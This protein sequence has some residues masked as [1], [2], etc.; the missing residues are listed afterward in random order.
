MNIWT[1]IK[2]SSKISSDFR[3]VSTSKYLGSKIYIHYIHY[4]FCS[5]FF[6]LL[7]IN[8]IYI[9]SALMRKIEAESATHWHG[10]RWVD[11]KNRFPQKIWATSVT[12]VLSRV[13][14]V[15]YVCLWNM[16]YLAT[17]FPSRSLWTLHLSAQPPLYNPHGSNRKKKKET[18]TQVM[19][20]VAPPLQLIAVA[21][22]RCN[23]PLLWAVA[24]THTH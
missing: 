15:K 8:L 22:H 5:C 6:F 7:S 2:K 3:V 13:C 4:K 21:I 10:Y 23:A 16:N 14:L 24:M 17:F 18:S 19:R 1:G 12:I 11:A 9:F 20:N